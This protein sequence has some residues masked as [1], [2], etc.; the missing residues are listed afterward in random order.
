MH[1]NEELSCFKLYSAHCIMLCNVISLHAHF[2][3][4]G[5]FALTHEEV[6]ERRKLL[7]ERMQPVGVAMSNINT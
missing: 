2:Q 5:E 4:L 3:I 7:L 1:L 6:L